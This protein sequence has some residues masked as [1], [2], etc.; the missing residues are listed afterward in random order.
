MYYVQTCRFWCWVG[1]SLGLCAVGSVQWC[2]VCAGNTHAWS[3]NGEVGHLLRAEFTEKFERA[4][5]KGKKTLNLPEILFWA[6]GMCCSW[7][8]P[9]TGKKLFSSAYSSLIRYGLSLSL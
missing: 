7:S 3:R 9:G 2:W 5:R 4:N 6:Y 1:I 8:F